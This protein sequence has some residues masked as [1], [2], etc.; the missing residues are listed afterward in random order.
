MIHGQDCLNTAISPL[1]DSAFV[2]R[3]GRNLDRCEILRV[4]AVAAKIRGLHLEGIL[5]V[6]PAFQDVA[7]YLSS[8]LPRLEPLLKQ[9]AT[10]IQPADASNIDEPERTVEIPVFYGGN[11]GCDL[12]EVADFAG[13]SAGEV[14][15]L[16]T[17]GEYIV[18][19]IGFSPGFAYLG[20]LN[21]ALTMGRRKSPRACI[22]AGSVGI[23]GAQ[24]GIYPLSTPGGWNII[25]RTTQSLFDIQ[26]D[27]PALLRVGDRVLF[28]AANGEPDDTAGPPDHRPTQAPRLEQDGMQGI[29]VLRPGLWTT[30][31]DLGRPGYRADGIPLGGAA[32]P[33]ALR[34]ANLL[35]GNS[36][37]AAAVEFTLTGPEIQFRCDALV[38]LTGAEVKGLP[39]WRPF[40]VRNGQTLNLDS[41][42]TGCRGYLAVSGGIRVPIVLGSRSTYKDATIGGLEGRPLRAGDVLPFQPAPPVD[43]V[44][45]QIS[46]SILP[47]YSASP[48]VRVIAAA[49]FSE[50]TTTWLQNSYEVSS[51]SN[52]MGVRLKGAVDTRTAVGLGSIPSSPVAPGTIQVPPD[53]NPIVLLA[54][55]QTI[56]GYPQ[57]GT[58]I[59]ADIPLVAQ[60]RPGDSIRFKQVTVNEARQMLIERERDLGFLRLG[61]EGK[62]HAN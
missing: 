39:S 33:L 42:T 51:R 46:H 30:V 24:T 23:G 62:M 9:V 10:L 59:T 37:S 4:A 16:H 31:Q 15:A 40:R 56:G 50:F 54:D 58:V 43:Q 61:L 57:I 34:V 21:P 41:L 6:V 14:V 49:Q 45:W 2:T 29:S 8:P 20:G 7:I 48:V 19:A 5:D 1:G 44:G 25:G 27:P 28:R 32:D 17:G 12:E 55:A 47:Q 11:D 36:E 38:A 35:V 13:I 53:G 18:H 52:R 60:L 3:V 22:K 26:R